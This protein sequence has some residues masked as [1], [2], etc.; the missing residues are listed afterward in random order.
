MTP[1]YFLRFSSFYV[2]FDGLHDNPRFPGREC[3]ADDADGY[4][5]AKRNMFDR[6][7]RI[8][9]RNNHFVPPSSKFDVIRNP[10]AVSAEDNPGCNG[11]HE[12]SNPFQCIRGRFGRGSVFC[13]EHDLLSLLWNLIV[14]EVAVATMPLPRLRFV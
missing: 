7:R 14:F 10:N 9:R 13:V 12:F 2:V 1:A 4:D 11:Q 5:H 8:E 6:G 3:K